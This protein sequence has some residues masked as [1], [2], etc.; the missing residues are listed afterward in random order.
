MNADSIAA[1]ES[2]RHILNE[3]SDTLEGG[4]VRMD[5]E[6]YPTYQAVLDC[7]NAIVSERLR[8]MKTMD[9]IMKKLEK[10][11]KENE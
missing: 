5:F 9:E 8:D 4:D 10:E 11:M 6:D 2:F 7:I 3:I 1:R